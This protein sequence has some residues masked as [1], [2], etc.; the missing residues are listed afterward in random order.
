MSG[1]WGLERIAG[2]IAERQTIRPLSHDTTLQEGFLAGVDGLATAAKAPTRPQFEGGAADPAY[3]IERDSAT[4]SR[5]WIPAAGRAAGD[6]NTR[7]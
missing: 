4:P 7:Q 2:K 3:G 5:A 6:C 1:E